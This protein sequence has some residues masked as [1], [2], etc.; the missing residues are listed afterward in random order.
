MEMVTEVQVR[1][2]INK[3]KP[4]SDSRET[5]KEMGFPDQD[6]AI[7]IAGVHANDRKSARHFNHSDN[8]RVWAVQSLFAC[9]VIGMSDAKSTPWNLRCN[10]RSHR[11]WSGGEELDRDTVEGRGQGNPGHAMNSTS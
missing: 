11:S 5:K 6:D 1:Q 10:I 8:I 3:P 7:G 9:P 2:P 4:N